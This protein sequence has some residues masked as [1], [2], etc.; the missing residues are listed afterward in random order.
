MG[1]DQA[2]FIELIIV[3]V[4]VG[5]GFWELKHNPSTGVSSSST[6]QSV[7]S[8]TDATKNSVTNP[9]QLDY[10]GALIV[11]KNA[12][13]QLNEDCQASPSAMTF[14]NNSYMM[15]DNRAS[16]ARTVKIGSTFTVP[17]YGFRILKLSSAQL[18]ITWYVD[19]GTSQNVATV[20]VQ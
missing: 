15:V 5:F 12:R 20:L 11:Y 17:A 7:N 14:K 4:L 6:D 8:A 13:L 19:C 10:A 18:P 2:L 9:K 16:V 3:L 1:K